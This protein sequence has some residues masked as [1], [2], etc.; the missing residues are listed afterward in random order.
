VTSPLRRTNFR[1]FFTGRLVSLLGSSMAPL[2]LA[3]AVLDASHS[4]GDLGVVLATRM[5]PNLVFLLVGGAVA[6][7]FPRRTVLVA[8]NLGAGLTQGSVAVILLTHHYALVAV[9]ALEFG[10][11]VLDAFT[12]PAL[13]GVLP[14]LVE[15]DG[16]QRA[17]SLLDSTR[18]A[19][20]IFGPSACGLLVVAIGPGAAIGF[21]ALTYLLAAA[22]LARL[23]LTA[24]IRAAR[25]TVVADIRD[26]WSEF[27]SIR[28]V[29]LVSGTFCLLNL[30]QT[31][32]W[33][34]LGPQLT[35]TAALWGFVL[36]A[37]AVGLLVMSALAYRLVVRHFVRV[38]LLGAALIGLPL[39]ALG[40]RL[41]AP[42]LL[43]AAFVAG[44]GSAIMS[45]GWDTSLQEHVPA[46]VLSRVASYDDLLSYAAIPIGQLS[47]G[48][49]AHAVGG[50][51]VAAGA[52]VLYAII[53]LAPLA[54][55]EVRDLP[56]ATVTVPDP[57]AAVAA[58]EPGDRRVR[59]GRTAR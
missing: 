44:L 19:I 31:G 11:G 43:G 25:S 33:Q 28:W 9:A 20:R 42:V 56:R 48:P 46:H 27:R 35:G 53:A 17:N 49:L 45:I 16:L 39:I 59:P 36:S 23:R 26:G 41:G 8:A 51:R 50:F 1:W 47:V 15:P 37:R 6:D 55:R 7:R 10:N 12:S 14:E 3:F 13:R 29:W 40:T 30:V 21:D 38:G 4:P 18:N 58:A 5:I 57:P 52:G 24:P 32:T 22:C 2:A 34:I 54:A